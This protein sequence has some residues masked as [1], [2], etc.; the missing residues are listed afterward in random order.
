MIT[1][2][3]VVI[4]FGVIRVRDRRRQILVHRWPPAL[5][6]AVGACLAAAGSGP[7]PAPGPNVIYHGPAMLTNTVTVPTHPPPAAAAPAVSYAAVPRARASEPLRTPPSGLAT[8][9][10]AAARGRAQDLGTSGSTLACRPRRQSLARPPPRAC[11]AHLHKL[12]ARAAGEPAMA[13]PIAHLALALAAVAASCSAAREL[14]ARDEHDTRRLL[15]QGV[16]G[17]SWGGAGRGARHRLTHPG[18]LGWMP[19][20]GAALA[21]WCAVPAVHTG[22]RACGRGSAALQPPTP[23]QRRPLPPL[24]TL[25]LLL[26]RRR[27]LPR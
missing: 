8:R 13:P 3:S 1:Q 22:A 21:R 2:C 20:R 18:P 9:R 14:A 4:E 11:G 5:L 12:C 17:A 16:G 24:S 27:Q 6:P 25:V 26:R 7:G 23:P 19:A 15:L 10:A